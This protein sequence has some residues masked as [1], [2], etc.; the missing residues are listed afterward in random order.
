MTRTR[1][2]IAG[3]LLCIAGTA[4]AGE[5]TCPGPQETLVRGNTAFALDLYAKLRE[6][7]KG[8]LF[9]SPYSVSTALAMTCAGAR[10]ET[11]AEMARV[12]H[13]D[14]D[15]ASLHPAFA[16][17]QWQLEEG[18][19]TGGYQIAIA[20]RLW[21]QAGYPFLDPFLAITGKQYGAPLAQADFVRETEAARQAINRWVEE[22]TRDRIRDLIAPGILTVDTRLVLA[23]AI[24]FKGKWESPFRKEATRPAPFH[25]SAGR[26]VDVPFMRQT[27]TFPFLQGDGF[28]V[29]ALPYQGKDLSMLL[30][31]PDAKEGLPALE[32][33]LSAGAMSRWIAELEKGH[34]EVAVLL[35]RFEMTYGCDLVTRLSAMGMPRA[36][37]AGLA[38]FSGMTGKRD[39]SIGAVI[40]KAFVKVDEEGS[41]AAAA[42]AVAMLS[43]GIPLPPKSFCADRPFLFLIRDNRSGSVLFMGRVGDP[44]LPAPTR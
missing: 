9:F 28:S 27:G 36:F 25:V 22:R 30:F 6:T 38:D 37:D 29:L 26:T 40:H 14:L 18:Q 21:G 17:L 41:E 5:T 15:P 39:L 8:N 12:L 44:G 35:P 11:A 1:S 13:F 16:G 34:E 20:N 7:E 23:N 19:K 4:A 31:L 10:G 3:A 2:R 24:W 33:K 32:E 43:K 42:T